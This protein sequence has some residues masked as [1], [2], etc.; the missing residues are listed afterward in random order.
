LPL[1]FV[2]R[3]KDR[4]GQETALDR[5]FGTPEWRDV[6]D[7]PDRPAGLLALFE[8]QLRKAGLSWVGAFRL[9][10]DPTNAYY[11]V[12]GSGHLKGWASIKEGFWAVDP[13]DGAE[14]L[15][16]KPVPPGQQTL[17][18]DAPNAP[19]ADTRP[20][21]EELR[22]RFGTELFTVEDAMDLTARS[23]F[24]DRHLKRA[25]LAPAEKA[26]RADANAPGMDGPP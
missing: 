24:L 23:R 18:V 21:L 11:I 2:N 26:G 4:H 7:G 16:S 14:Y 9:Q 25:T 10:P 20:L 6:R 22:E 1:S 8:E 13:V 19:K 15:S 12:G 3:F 17:D 5:F